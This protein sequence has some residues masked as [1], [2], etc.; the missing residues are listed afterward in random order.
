MTFQD[1][2]SQA[3]LDYNL[4]QEQGVKWCINKETEDNNYME[5]VTSNNSL[6]RRGGIVADEMGL[7]KTITMIGLMYLNKLP[8][9]LIVV[10]VVLIDQWKEAVQNYLSCNP[11]I[12]HG[13]H[14]SPY[15]LE[16]ALN[17]DK[18]F[19][20]ITT[21]GVLTQRKMRDEQSIKLKPKQLQKSDYLNGILYHLLWD[22]I[23]FDEAHHTRNN[24]TQKF[25]SCNMLI[26]KIKWC[27]TGTPIQNKLRDFRNLLRLL[28][29]PP[30]SMKTTSQLDDIIRHIMLR[31]TKSSVG[32]TLPR[33]HITN[34]TVEWKSE[35]EK[36]LNLKFMKYKSTFQ[37]QYNVMEDDDHYESDSDDS[38]NN[39]TNQDAI[40]FPINEIQVSSDIQNNNRKNIFSILEDR[41]LGLPGSS[42]NLTYHYRQNHLLDEDVDRCASLLESNLLTSMIRGRQMCIYPGLI[43]P[44]L[45]EHIENNNLS[46]GIYQL[47]KYSSKLDAVIEHI[48]QH[49]SNNHENNRKI[50]FC[51]FKE[52]MTQLYNRFISEHNSIYNK[53]EIACYDGTLNYNTR[54]SIINNTNLKLLIIQIQT[55][56]D[57]L[58]LQHY[59]EIYFVSPCWNPSMED[60]AI[61]RCHRMGQTKQTFVYRF[62]MG[63]DDTRITNMDDYIELNQRNK[64]TLIRE[65]YT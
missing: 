45:K 34:I 62:Q 26:S 64:R 19:V 60:Q 7:G 8:S 21:Y 27:V 38:I 2:I 5:E 44:K 43:L 22:R 46:K 51:N 63:F 28:D 37:S 65:L 9:T 48:I 49:Q 52:E 33:L 42:R 35:L 15:M 13:P 41:M 17:D 32:I 4:Y 40:E 6:C 30:K 12:Y 36:K 61:A 59:N 10:P 11:V 14:K 54:K 16:K 31:R 55:A 18:P 50:V 24:S 58:N 20:V 29:I 3:N 23:I 1:F 57:G 39:D 25:W 47:R 53:D 56:C